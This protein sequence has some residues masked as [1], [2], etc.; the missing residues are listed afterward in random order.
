[1]L[2]YV[3]PLLKFGTLSVFLYNPALVFGPY[4]LAIITLAQ[5]H[6][7]AKNNRIGVWHANGLINHSLCNNTA[8]WGIV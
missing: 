2:H 4:D 5:C 1:V 3:V 8:F 6:C 7:S